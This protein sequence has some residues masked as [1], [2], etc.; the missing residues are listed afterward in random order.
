MERIV[1]AL[2][3]LG[4]TACSADSTPPTGT[5]G[6][7][8][9]TTTTDCAGCV[10]Q[11]GC[12]NGDQPEACGSAGGLCVVCEVGEFCTEAGTCVGAP[13]CGP[14]NCQGCCDANGVCVDGDI[15]SECGRGGFACQDCAGEASCEDGGCLAKCGPDTCAGCCDATGLCVDGDTN[16]SCGKG[17]G[18]CAN[19][20]SIT[21]VCSGAECVAP[22]CAANCNGCCNGAD[23][24]VVP[25]ANQCGSAG[26]ACED[27]GAG[28]TC[29][30]GACVVRA[31]SEW[32]IALTNGGVA[33]LSPTGE[34]WDGFNGLPDPVVEFVVGGSST[35]S[36]VIEDTLTPVWNEDVATARGSDLFDGL[37]IRYKDSDVALDDEICEITVTLSD[38]AP[39]FD[40]GVVQLACAGEPASFVRWR[41]TPR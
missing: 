16:P 38:D 21:S 8:N 15:D 7:T 35:S 37:V 11:S 6:A 36:S 4:V 18:V 10:H 24:V 5:N 1:I 9:S 33:A 14:D 22:D 39:E 40:G 27:C 17:G 31:D 26:E 28:R 29:N 30:T 25:N 19:C 34:S 13:S 32:V 20:E 23:C 12:V 41:L 2:F 3:C